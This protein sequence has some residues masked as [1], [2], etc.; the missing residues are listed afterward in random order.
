AIFSWCRLRNVRK[1]VDFPLLF[2]TESQA[3]QSTLEILTNAKTARKFTTEPVSEDHIKQILLAGLNAPSALNSQPW[4]FTVVTNKKILNQIN[5]AMIAAR[6]KGGSGGQGA[7]NSPPP[8]K[9]GLADAPVA[10]FVYG[11]NNLFTDSFDC[12]LATEAMSIAALSLGY[13]TKIL[14]SPTIVLNGEKKAYFDQLLQVP[15]GYSNV[16][17]LIIGRND[18]SVDATAGASTRK[19]MEEKVRF[20]K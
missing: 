19:P 1:S 11:T 7:P 18:E 20:I 16:A 9:L 6:T 17:V 14:A 2:K 12:G 10:I 8:K 15:E 13:G 4:H 5:E 3:A